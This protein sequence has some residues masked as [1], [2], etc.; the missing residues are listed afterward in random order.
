VITVTPGTS[1]RQAARTM[2]ECEIGGMPVIENGRVIGV[3]T[4]TD[5]LKALLR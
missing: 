5:A 2:V 1:I 4:T 3:I